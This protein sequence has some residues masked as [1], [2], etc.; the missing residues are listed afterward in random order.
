MRRTIGISAGA[1]V[2]SMMSGCDARIAN[3][4][5]QTEAPKLQAVSLNDQQDLGAQTV[6]ADDGVGRPCAFDDEI[7]GT[8]DQCGDV[9]AV[10]S[11]SKPLGTIQASSLSVQYI[12]NQVLANDTFFAK[13]VI[14]VGQTTKVS[15]S[16]NVITVD[17]ASPY[18]MQVRASLWHN[19][20]WNGKIV[21]DRE[22]AD[23]LGYGQYLSLAC[24]VRGAEFGELKLANCVAIFKAEKPPKA[25]AISEQGNALDAEE[26]AADDSNANTAAAQPLPAAGSQP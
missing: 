13:K 8:K 5:N 21:S 19:Q 26:V 18:E 17:Y 9:A 11:A 16:D 23:H 12:R 24:D 2:L 25:A 4:G 20:I 14:L 3:K 6:S 10:L 22:L 7:T 1:M 15:E